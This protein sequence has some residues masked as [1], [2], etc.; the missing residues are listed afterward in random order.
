MNADSKTGGC[1][2][3]PGLAALRTRWSAFLSLFAC[4]TPREGILACLVCFPFKFRSL[5]G[6]GLVSSPL[7]DPAASAAS[8]AVTLTRSPGDRTIRP[9]VSTAASRSPGDE[10]P[11]NCCWRKMH[12]YGY[13]A[14]GSVDVLWNIVTVGVFS[15]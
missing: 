11:L 8:V 10:C 6:R 9:V 3:A 7:V 13:G 4:K 1:L 14:A 15:S 5:L 2:T 12:H